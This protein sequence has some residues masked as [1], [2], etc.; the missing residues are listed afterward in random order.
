MVE[1]RIIIDHTVLRGS[2]SVPWEDHT[3]RQFQRESRERCKMGKHALLVGC[4][5]PGTQ[6]E[7][8]GCVNDV[9]AMRSLLSRFYGFQ[10]HDFTILVDNDGSYPQPTGKNIKLQLTKMVDEAQP[11]DVL[12]FHFS[13][14]G[15]QIPGT[16]VDEADLKDEAICPTDMNLILDDDLREIVKKLND[17]VFFTFVS[18]CCHS[19]GMLDHAGIQISGPKDGTSVPQLDVGDILS[20]FGLRGVD[21][22]AK[23]S[24]GIKNRS[25]PVNDLMAILSEQLGTKVE[26]GNLKG[27][28]G[29]L[30]GADASGKIQK[31]L[32]IACLLLDSLEGNGGGSNGNASPNSGCLSVLTMIIKKFFSPSSPSSGVALPQPGSKPPTQEQL[33]EDKGV[34]ITGCQSNETSA[35][36]CPSGKKARAYGALTNAIVTVVTAHHKQNPEEPLLYTNLVYSVRDVLSKG[37]YSQNPC[38]EGSKKTAAADF[39]NGNTAT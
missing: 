8:H 38:L 1:S 32:E 3:K 35:D 14:H 23:K 28:L 6:A 20:S 10:E 30:F 4:N 39:V 2:R 5:Y 7:L 11:G 36:A 27:A 19:G 9:F 22:E 21:E 31:Y 29:N 25:L 37:G 16:K 34:L 17:D 24:N 33:H 12:L 13:G 15:T 18:D 26:L